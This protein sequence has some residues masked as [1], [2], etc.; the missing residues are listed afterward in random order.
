MNK[1]ILAS[2]SPRRQQL[3]TELGLEF[4]IDISNVEELH[5]DSLPL[6]QLCEH[7]AALK[8][9]DVAHR[10]KNAIV[11]GADTLV[12]LEQTPLGKPKSQT[13]AIKTLQWLSGKTHTVCTG[14]CLIHQGKSQ[15]FSELTSVTFTELDQAT[16]QAYMEKVNVMDKAGSYAIQEH[17]EMIIEKI[18]GDFSNVM[19]LPQKLVMKK[20][21]LLGIQSIKK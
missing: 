19:G 2:G 13:E 8:A 15:T 10:H 4:V 11:L 9:K 12:Y 5:D 14:L 3:L 17:A 16:I 1:F 21:A 7:N 18:D 20:L 6:R